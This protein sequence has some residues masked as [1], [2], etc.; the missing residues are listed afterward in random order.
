VYNRQDLE[1][2]L[3]IELKLEFRADSRLRKH[4]DGLDFLGYIIRE[5]YLLTR[6]RVVNNYIKKT[7]KYLSSYEAQQGKMSLEEI[8]QFLSVQASFVGHIK[9]ANS[10][11][12]MNRVGVLDENNPFDFDRT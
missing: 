8:K 5:N 1:A 12:L 6:Q 4:S 7:A 9:H 2:Y 3:K 10:F 11:N